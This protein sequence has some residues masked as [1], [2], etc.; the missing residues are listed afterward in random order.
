MSEPP[1]SDR[2]SFD[3]AM[4]EIRDRLDRADFQRAVLDYAFSLHGDVKR[5][6]GLIRNIVKKRKRPYA[7]G[8]G[9]IFC[10][11]RYETPTAQATTLK[12][13]PTCPWPALV[14]EAEKP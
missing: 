9:C 8:Y 3:A 12:H 1:L 11:A 7:T 4:D 2:A 6:R 10:R 5:L 13:A 14:A